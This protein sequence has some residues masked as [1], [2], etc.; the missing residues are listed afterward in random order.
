LSTIVSFDEWPVNTTI[1][2]SERHENGKP[3]AL[4]GE[5]FGEQFE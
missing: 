4:F 1:E 3:G 2:F 5:Q